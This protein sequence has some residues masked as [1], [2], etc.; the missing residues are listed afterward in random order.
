[1]AI[2]RRINALIFC[3]IY[4]SFGCSAIYT[5]KTKKTVYLHKLLKWDCLDSVIGDTC[6]H[7]RFDGVYVPIIHNAYDFSSL[8]QFA[9]DNECGYGN[10]EYGIYQ[11][12]CD[13]IDVNFYYNS[14]SI[15]QWHRSDYQ[16]IIECDG[17]LR[18]IYIDGE[19]SDI[20]YKF[21]ECKH[22]M[23]YDGA[24]LLRIQ[25]WMYCKKNKMQ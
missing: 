20:R 6:N 5:P 10:F 24:N 23:W 4:I 16:F 22:R 19:R 21:F 15:R 7:I 25:D 17:S 9:S 1:M 8:I 14:G 12:R 11:D 13:T 2:M 3:I 18:A